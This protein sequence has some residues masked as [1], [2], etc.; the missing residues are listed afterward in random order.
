MPTIDVH[1]TQLAY[2]PTEVICF[3]EGLVGMPNLRKMVLVR[4]EGVEPFLWLAAVDGPPT[5][6][7]VADPRD[8][9]SGYVPDVPEDVRCRLGLE[10]GEAP[11][12]LAVVTVARDGI[13]STANLRAPV[14][15]APSAMRGAQAILTSSVFRVDER[16]PVAEV[17]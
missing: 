5:T 1:G 10:S 3:D 15:V 11:L 9:F 2:D 16:L 7:L 12:V 14:F 4:E 17:A 6:F 8:L 13:S